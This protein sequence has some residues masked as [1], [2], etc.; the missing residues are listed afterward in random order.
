[1]SLNSFY[2]KLENETNIF[3]ENNNRL[4]NVEVWKISISI[5]KQ[6][7]LQHYCELWNNNHVFKAE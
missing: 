1:M 4:G 5:S 6:S 2:K 3:N 7:I